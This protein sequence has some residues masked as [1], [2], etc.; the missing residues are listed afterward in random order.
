MQEKVTGLDWRDF[1]GINL[2]ISELVKHYQSLIDSGSSLSDFWAGEIE[3]LKAT[4]KKINE[5]RSI[6]L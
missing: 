6:D 3:T 4:Q 5:N 2:G 1:V